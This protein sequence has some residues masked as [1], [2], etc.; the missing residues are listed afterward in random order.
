MVLTNE[1]LLPIELPQLPEG[2]TFIN[3]DLQLVEEDGFCV[4]F[5]HCFPIYRF[6][7]ADSV[8][9]R[10]V[11]VALRLGKHATQGEIAAALGHSIRTQMRWEQHYREKGLEGLSDLPRSGRPRGVSPRNA[12]FWLGGSRKGWETGRSLGAWGWARP[13][14]AAS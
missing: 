14:C 5:Q 4:V 3:R 9:F 2:H 10:F 13:P 12:P 11:A 7:R 8:T 6:A 1:L